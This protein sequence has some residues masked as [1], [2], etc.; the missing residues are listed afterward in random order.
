M[1][2]KSKLLFQEFQFGD[3]KKCRP[4]VLVIENKEGEQTK[5][6]Q[7]IITIGR[8]DDNDRVLHNQ[9]VSRRH[10]INVNY[11]NDVCLYDMGS[12]HGTFCDG[13]PVKTSVFLDG[14]HKIRIAE[15]LF[16]ILS[17]EGILL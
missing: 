2:L 1:P 7:P 6:I 4:N 17:K 8:L 5:F 14:R 10:C 9:N 11:A 12:T 3:L 16:S 15:T 13:M